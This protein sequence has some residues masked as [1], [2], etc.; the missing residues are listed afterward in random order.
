MEERIGKKE[1]TKEKLNN[2]K[3]YENVLMNPLHNAYIHYN[4]CIIQRPY[5]RQQTPSGSAPFVTNPSH[6][7]PVPPA[8]T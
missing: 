7:I 6:V 8:L 3:L 5:R 1:R 2:N 4:R